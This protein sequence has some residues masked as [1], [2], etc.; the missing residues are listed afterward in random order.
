MQRKLERNH[1]G[2]P[3]DTWCIRRIPWDGCC[4]NAD[5]CAAFD[6]HCVSRS[7]LGIHFRTAPKTCYDTHMECS[8]H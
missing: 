5:I 6:G 7:F 3:A 2:Q 4:V 8:G 1:C